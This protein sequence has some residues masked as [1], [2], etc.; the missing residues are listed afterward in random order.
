MSSYSNI[1]NVKEGEAIV[2]IGN[3]TGNRWTRIRS[4]I[5]ESCAEFLGVVILTGFGLGVNCQA[6]LSSNPDVVSSPKGNWT[7]VALGWGT[8]AALAVWVS[9]GISGG[10]I[11]PAVTLA[12]ATFRGFPWKKVPAY[13]LSQLLGGIVGAAIVYA[14]YF[15]AI[16]IYEGG[17]NIRTLR[18]AGLFG[19]YPLAYVTNA[20]A[21]FSEF[22]GAALLMIAILAMCD[23]QNSGPSGG[24]GPLVIFM[25]FVG[26]AVSFGMETSFGI[27][28]ARD[29]GPRILTSMVGYGKVVYDFRKQYWLWCAIIAPILGTQAGALVYDGLLYT[30]ED[31]ILNKPAR[32]IQSLKKIDAKVDQAANV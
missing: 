6:S 8:G 28:P 12:M 5:R 31:S 30:G 16:D 22:L 1:L 3:P 9:G 23:K 21:F 13:I 20:S 11:N 18:T 4:V 2:P 17:R 19:T 14:N 27:N 29:L 24:L 15:H 32:A 26:I 7:T 25:I 10:H